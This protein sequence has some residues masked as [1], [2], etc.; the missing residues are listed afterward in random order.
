MQFYQ[1]MRAEMASGA[2]RWAGNDIAAELKPAT[3]YY[4]AEK[5]HQQYLEKGGRAGSG[6]SAAKGCTDKIRCYG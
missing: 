6:Q 5:Y 2:R 1:R 4:I 3:D